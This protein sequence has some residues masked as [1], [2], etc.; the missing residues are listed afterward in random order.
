MNLSR[1]HVYLNYIPMIYGVL[2]LYTLNYTLYNEH[3]ALHIVHCTMYNVYD[4]LE[5]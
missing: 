3:C 5:L 1:P 2:E 4:V